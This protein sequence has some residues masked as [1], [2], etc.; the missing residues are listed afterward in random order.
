VRQIGLAQPARQL[1]PD[2]T[3]FFQHLGLFKV[4]LDELVERQALGPFHFQDR[5]PIAAD[6]HALVEEG[7]I[8]HERQFELFE[9]EADLLVALAQA[10]DSP[11][12]A[13]DGPGAAGGGSG[14]AVNVGEVAGAGLGQADG[15]DGRLAAA[16]LR[17][18]EA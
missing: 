14:D 13:L 9:V 5:I 12:E 18:A 17:V 2:L 16:Q 11:G 8:D 15:V 1:H 3:E 6:A 4:V 7:E 10:G